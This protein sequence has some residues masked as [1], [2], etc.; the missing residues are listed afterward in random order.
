MVQEFCIL[1]RKIVSNF[2][3]KHNIK[4]KHAVS[5]LKREKKPLNDLTNPDLQ[6]DIKNI[7]IN[8]KVKLEKA[9][10]AYSWI[11]DNVPGVEISSN[12]QVIN[13]MKS[14]NILE[15]LK[16]IYSN[17]KNISKEKL[18]SY[19]IWISLIDFPEKFVD[20]SKIK[21][22]IYEETRNTLEIEKG[23]KRKLPFHH[24]LTPHIKKKEKIYKEENNDN[25]LNNN[26]NVDNSNTDENDHNEETPVEIEDF[27]SFIE[28]Y[29]KTPEYKKTS[30]NLRSKSQKKLESEKKYGSG[31]KIFKWIN[32]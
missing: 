18:D 16:D 29:T 26:N 1:P 8:N 4:D 2:V 9:S 17:A 15:F 30:R 6:S 13:P 10:T 25:A 14:I 7:F 21:N 32:Y 28:D 20:N 12:G 5:I 31:R 3:N 11:L 19:K 24:N 23:N 22:H 27:H